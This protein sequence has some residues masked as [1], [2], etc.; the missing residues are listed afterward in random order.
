M[1]FNFWSCEKSSL[2]CPI[3]YLRW[4]ISLAHMSINIGL[5]YKTFSQPNNPM[6][7]AVCAECEYDIN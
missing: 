7:E 3:T 2:G 4:V 1:K 5:D 6:L